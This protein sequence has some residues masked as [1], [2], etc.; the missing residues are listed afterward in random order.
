MRAISTSLRHQLFHH[1]RHNLR[2]LSTSFTPTY[3]D[4]V[5]HSLGKPNLFAYFTGLAN[6]HEAINLGQGFPTYGTPQFVLDN[7]TKAVSN[8]PFNQYTRPGGHPI[9]VDQ[10]ASHYSSHFHRPL[11]PLTNICTF[12]G[13]QFGLFD[14]IV[15]Y[16]NEGDEMCTIEPFFGPYKQ[17]ADVVGATTVGVP[18][19]PKN[20]ASPTMTADD[21]VLDLEELKSVLTSK[22]KL[23]ILNTPHNPTGKVFSTEELQGIA[24]VVR[25]FPNLIVISDEVYEY[26]TFQ[27]KKHER[28][29]N[30]DDMWDR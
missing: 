30:M 6:E 2:L 3:S 23:L 28:F 20:N 17:A 7:V 9:L 26:S 27:P 19:R 1:H 4:A 11:D 15:S 25:K 5:Q 22:T 29:A 24:N 16:L 13:A 10:L 21:F 12:S 8:P 14:C 18:L